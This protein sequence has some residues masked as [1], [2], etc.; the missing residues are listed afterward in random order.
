MI[1]LMRILGDR[2]AGF[3]LAMAV[4]LNLIVGSLVMNSHPELYPKF[5]H[6]DLNYFFRP[7]RIEHAWL[8]TL[9]L[10]FTLFGINLLACIGDSIVRLLANRAGR[11]KAIA[12]LLLHAAL[13]ITMAAHLYEGFSASTQRTLITAQGMELPGLGKVQV[14]TLNNIHYPDGSLKDTEVTLRFSQPGGQQ[15]SRDIAFNEPALF[16]LGR[17][18]VVM[19]SGQ[20]MPAGIVISREAG[21]GELR[22]ETGRP[23]RLESGSLLLQGIHETANGLPFARILWQ[24][25][26]GDQ[27]HI[28][29][30]DA[31]MPHS[32]IRVDGVAY[33]F[34]DI[35]ETP[36]IV[37]II[38]HN[39]AVPL[40]LVSLAL[41][42]VG[43]I[44]L[45]RWMLASRQA[46]AQDARNG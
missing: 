9:L 3:L 44:L 4:V 40:M 14:E 18:Q 43:I 12:A 10:V 38:R 21:A 27:Q 7:A 36:S 33:Q 11:A 20:M 45:I 46:G 1:N 15:F 8:Y 42:T 28:M 25:G 5:F 22:L 17:R 39:P 30:L 34:A 37:A 35:I 13:V 2:H 16:D 6:L 32:Q 26:N 23:L 41:A 19:L 24:D 31:G 29:A